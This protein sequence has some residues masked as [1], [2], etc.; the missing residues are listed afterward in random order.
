MAGG[1]WGYK[2]RKPFVITSKRRKYSSNIVAWNATEFP[3]NPTAVTLAINNAQTGLPTPGILKVAN[4]KVSVDLN[5]TTTTVGT[6]PAV[7]CYILFVPEGFATADLATMIGQHP[8]YIMA[9]KTVGSPTPTS[10]SF[11]MQTINMSTRLKR[12]LNSGDSIQLFFGF[13]NPAVISKVYATG[14]CRYWICYN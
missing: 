14:M 11:D 5:I 2:Y 12:N 9:C 13:S 1:R 7:L 6:Y 4:I 3:T 10:T 8:E